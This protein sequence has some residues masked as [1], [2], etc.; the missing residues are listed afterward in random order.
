MTERDDIGFR[1]MNQMWNAVIPAV[2]ALLGVL[3]GNMLQARRELRKWQLER[4]AQRQRDREQWEREDR[5]R[6]IEQKR[7]IYADFLGK[8]DQYAEVVE[9]AIIYCINHP[10]GRDEE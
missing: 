9:R 8:L 4:D 3:L 6:F 1:S 2:A 7:E 5:H 10:P